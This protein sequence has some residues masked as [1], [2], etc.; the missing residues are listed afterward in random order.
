MKAAVLT[1]INQIQIDDVPSPKLECQS[2]VL[3]K[4]NYVGICGSD[5]HYYETGHIGSQVVE[6]PFI[7]GHEC[8]GTVVEVGKEVEN[9]KPNDK[10]VIDPAQSCYQCDQCKA[11]RENTCRNLKFLGTPGQGNGCLCEYIAIDHRSCYPVG[12]GITLSQGV[13]C[14][15]LAIGVYSVEQAKLNQNPAIAIL[16]TGPIG[17]SCLAAA[18]S[19]NINQICAADKI[20]ERVKAAVDAGTVCSLNPLTSDIA[21]QFLEK[22]SFGFDAVFECAGQQEAI[23]TA[24]EILKPGGKLIVVGIP[25]E[26]RICFAVDKIRRKE[27]TIVNIRRQNRCTQKAIDLIAEKKVSVDY[28]ITHN[29]KLEDAKAGFDLVAGY[30]DGVIKTLIEI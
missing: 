9:L 30:S 14:E 13:L 8:S 29:Y 17:L 3:V 10:V 26:D 22:Q 20:D 7:V 1:G 11:G 15:P 18:K 6:Y 12:D 23:D 2:D 4:I 27:I 21:K 16:G 5:V 28:M 24:V 19:Q 25:R